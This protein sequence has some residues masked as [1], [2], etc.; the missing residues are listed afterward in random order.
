[1]VTAKTLLRQSSEPVA[2]AAEVQPAIKD[3]DLRD[4]DAFL[5][6]LGQRVRDMRAVRGLSRKVLSRTSGIS[7]RYIAQLEAGQGN[8]S[9]L[10]LRRVCAATG[11]RLEDLVAEP[12][13]HNP[14]WLVLRDMIQTARPEQIQQARALLGGARPLQPVSGPP[15]RIAL[16]GLRGAGKSTLG[17]RVA[18]RLGW[19][20]VELN[21]EIE[22]ANALSVPEIFA[23]YGQDGYR[24]FE[25]RSLQAL[26][27]RPGPMILATG[28]GI[29]AEPLTF[30]LLLSS[31]FTI[32]L[33]AGPEEHMARVRAQG[34][35]RPMSADRAAMQELRAILTS[36][37]GLYSRARGVVDTSG[38]TE[39][40]AAKRLEQLVTANV[41]VSAPA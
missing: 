7:E 32:W 31:F 28:G 12:G 8:V 22:R 25:Q 20:F 40:E 37:E 18:E 2:E 30:D 10:L 35:L 3:V 29:V 6:Q 11:I 4:G 9:I 1:M 15:M 26:I 14:D 16:I 36:R 33:K 23:I 41:A 5:L 19:T 27:A 21:K 13:S 24:R 39:D 34:D 17:R 38:L